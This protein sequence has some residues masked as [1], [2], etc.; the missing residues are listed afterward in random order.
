MVNHLVK[1]YLKKIS[2][3]TIFICFFAL[4]TIVIS[5][6]AHADNTDFP[7]DVGPICDFGVC[8]EAVDLSIGSIPSATSAQLDVAAYFTSSSGSMRID[9]LNLCE[10]DI[11]DMA[12]YEWFGYGPFGAGGKREIVTTFDF[13]NFDGTS[14]APRAYG[15]FDSFCHT[16]SVTINFSN[17][18]LDPATNLYA[19]Y[20]FAKLPSGLEGFQNHFSYKLL[21][22]GYFVG[23]KG[24]ESAPW[25]VSMGRRIRGVSPTNM[26]YIYNFGSD[27]SIDTNTTKYLRYYDIDNGTDDGVQENGPIVMQLYEKTKGASS[28]VLIDTWTP[29]GRV[30]NISGSR[31]F[32]AKPDAKYKWVLTNVYFQNLIQVAVPFNGI[33]SVTECKEQH[34]DATYQPAVENID[35]EKGSANPDSKDIRFSIKLASDAPCRSNLSGDTIIDRITYFGWDVRRNAMVG[36]EHSY[37]LRNCSGLKNGDEL[38][39]YTYNVSGL[40]GSNVGLMPFE[41]RFTSTSGKS[42]TGY[43]GITIY[44]VPY[45]R[46]YGSDVYAT[47]CIGANTGIIFNPNSKTV[48][49]GAAAQYSAIAVSAP[50][51]NAMQSAAFRTSV[52]V[53]QL[54]L[55]AQWA[56]GKAPCETR[57]I[58]SLPKS[59]GILPSSDLSSLPNKSYYAASGDTTVNATSTINGK[60]ITIK[61]VNGSLYISSNI[62][63]NEPGAIFN[64]DTAPVILLIA[65]KDIFIN[66]NVTRIDAIL[67]AKGTISTCASGF[68]VETARQNCTTK[69]TINGALGASDIRFLRSKGTRLLGPLNENNPYAG[70]LLNGSTGSVG[71]AAE[72]INFPAYLN[73]ATPYLNN[74]SS[75][76]YQSLFNAAPLF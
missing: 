15:I 47:A 13:T 16:N 33:F 34:A 69:L 67:I 50:T 54:G 71:E 35:Y 65:D 55:S 20:I 68:G 37:D 32:T 49:A 62:I 5:S 8:D 75:T 43:G 23:L 9:N 12:G 18:K 64:N 26:D 28:F 51:S 36:T 19:L 10:N 39:G 46:F 38:S 14:L 59:N 53:P 22:N 42:G 1:N 60:K 31:A 41:T 29:P 4:L 58:D 63:V 3:F 7:N 45:T 30:H 40:D 61:A 2:I 44:E 48:G 66:S 57:S 21:S 11:G 70:S 73:F 76:G 27:C 56:A 24:S 74:N 25:N 52:P 72:V 6:N 17:L